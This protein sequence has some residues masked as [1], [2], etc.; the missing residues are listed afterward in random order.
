MFLITD[1][2]FLWGGFACAL[3]IRLQFL[4]PIRKP[5]PIFAGGQHPDDHALC[6]RA[7]SWDPSGRVLPGTL[8]L[9]EF[10][11]KGRGLGL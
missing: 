11:I 2:C 9:V 6:L 3:G 8:M 5:S 4:E 10:H 7:S 1:I